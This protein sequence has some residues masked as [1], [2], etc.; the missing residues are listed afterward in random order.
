MSDNE[1]VGRLRREFGLGDNPKARM[2]LYL[3]LA[4]HAEGNDLALKVIRECA[5]EAK[6]KNQPG[7]WFCR[8]VTLRLTEAGVMKATERTR[9]LVVES[10]LEQAVIPFGN[11]SKERGPYARN[12]DKP[13]M[14]SG[15]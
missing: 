8:T 7:R 2:R 13:P 15:R 5:L 3:L 9:G 10:I 1:L 6:G 4:R 11:E 12:Q 14:S